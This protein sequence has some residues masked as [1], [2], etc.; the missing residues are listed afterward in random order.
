MYWNGKE[1]RPGIVSEMLYED[2]I[3]KAYGRGHNLRDTKLWRKGYVAGF[4][5]PDGNGRFDAFVRLQSGY[6]YLGN[7]SYDDLFE[8]EVEDAYDWRNRMLALADS[9]SVE[10]GIQTLREIYLHPDFRYE[11]SKAGLRMAD[12]PLCM[13]WFVDYWKYVKW[14]ERGNECSL[15]EVGFQGFID[16]ILDPRYVTEYLLP[17]GCE[18]DEGEM[19]ARRLEQLNRKYS[20]VS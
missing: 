14:N 7:Y 16:T 8:P 5:C 17:E 10:Q 15:S 6:R 1:Y 19:L 13:D 3:D 20:K 4:V 12:D 9:Q 18:T 2:Y 11:T